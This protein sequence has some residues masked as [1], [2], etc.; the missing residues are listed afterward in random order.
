MLFKLSYPGLNFVLTLGYLNPALNNPAQVVWC[1]VFS[2]IPTAN[3]TFTAKIAKTLCSF[4]FWEDS[5]I[6]DF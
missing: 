6:D 4:F 3:V 2:H 1:T 5:S